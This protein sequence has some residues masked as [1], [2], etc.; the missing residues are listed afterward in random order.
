M[1]ERILLIEDDPDLRKILEAALAFSNY[2]VTPAAD[3]LEG[4]IQAS[5]QPFDLIIADKIMPIMDGN[6]FVR[7]L[8]RITDPPPPVIML[9]GDTSPVNAGPDSP[10]KVTCFKPI[11]LFNLLEVVKSV[12]NSTLTTT[13]PNLR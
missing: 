5:R 9:T 12:L 1:C 7:E 13:T 8:A 4:L 10:V 6:E 2:H 11:S 3:G